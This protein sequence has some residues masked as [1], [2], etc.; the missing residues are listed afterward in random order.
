MIFKNRMQQKIGLEPNPLL[1]ID[2]MDAFSSVGSQK[3]I[4][5]VDFSIDFIDSKLCTF[6][7]LN[8]VYTQEGNLFLYLYMSLYVL[9]SAPQPFPN[10]SHQ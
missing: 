9:V 2:A 5:K 10:K 3:K 7:T 4:R 1:K 6:S 8:Y